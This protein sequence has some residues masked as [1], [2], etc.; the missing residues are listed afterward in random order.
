MAV[1]APLH[2]DGTRPRDGL[3]GA[4]DATIDGDHSQ[5]LRSLVEVRAR[6]AV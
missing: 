5:V 2:V 6:N 3:L 1:V 4:V